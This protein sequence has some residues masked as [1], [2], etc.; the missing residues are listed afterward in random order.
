MLKSSDLSLFHVFIIN[1]IYIFSKLD[2]AYRILA[3]H[4]RMITVCLCDGALPDSSPKM[5]QILRRIFRILRDQFG[6]TNG[7]DSAALVFNLTSQVMEN[8]NYHYPES[9]YDKH[10]NVIYTV[11]QF[12]AEYMEILKADGK[13]DLIYL[14]EVLDLF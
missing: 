10:L 1:E 9:S 11:L 14:S 2:T 8:L 6:I 5:R 3:D 12:E 4:I 7:H 13:K